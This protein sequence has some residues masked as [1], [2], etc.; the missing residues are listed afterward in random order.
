MP[1]M[2]CT[3]YPTAAGSR[4]ERVHRVRSM[5]VAGCEGRT[6]ALPG[7]GRHPTVQRWPG[8]SGAGRAGFARITLVAGT[9]K[10][11]GR[12]AGRSGSGL[13]SESVD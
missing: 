13:L 10:G 2:R 11:W 8:R 7:R 3:A 6:E 12:G 1:L 5:L 4:I 9:G